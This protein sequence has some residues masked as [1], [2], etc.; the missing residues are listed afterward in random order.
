M[1]QPN[2]TDK[3]D[4]VLLYIKIWLYM[5][6]TKDNII[7]FLQSRL[8]NGV[9]VSRLITN[10]WSYYIK[11]SELTDDDFKSLLSF[12]TTNAV[13]VKKRNGEY[14]TVIEPESTTKY[15]IDIQAGDGGT[16]S[17]NGFTEVPEGGDLIIVFIPNEGYKAD[18]IVIDGSKYQVSGDNYTMKNI[19]SNHDVEVD[20]RRIT[21]YII[22]SS[23][24]G[25][26]LSPNGTVEVPYGDSRNFI[27]HPNTGFTISDVLVD[28]TSVGTV[29][30][31]NF[32]NVTSDHTIE[33][34]FDK[35]PTYNIFA[36]A[37]IYGSISP[38]GNVTVYEGG[39]Q[40][41][42]ITPNTARQIDSVLVDGQ[43][44]G[45][46]S[47]YTF[48]NVR[49]DHTISASF[50]IA[51]YPI[52]T[53]VE[54]SGGTIS[55][56]GTQY[57]EYAGSKTFEIIPN[58]G[59]QI[60]Q[61]IINKYDHVY[62]QDVTQQV[63]NNNNTYTFTNVTRPQSITAS[64]RTETYTI[65]PTCDGYSTINPDYMMTV[66]HGGSC[67]FTMGVKNP[68][69]YEIANVLVDGQ[70]VG[71]VSSYTFSNVT[72]NHTIN[73][74]SQRKSGGTYTIQ[75]I[76]E[77]GDTMIFYP[78]SSGTYTVKSG[79]SPDGVEGKLWIGY[80]NQ[81]QPYLIVTDNGNDISTLWSDDG[82]WWG[83]DIASY[84]PFA[85][86]T[87][88][89]TVRV[90]TSATPPTPPVTAGTVTQQT[91]PIKNG[92]VEPSGKIVTLDPNGK[93]YFTF[94]PNANYK[95]KSIDIDKVD[96]T[97]TVVANGGIYKFNDPTK[98][99]LMSVEFRKGGSTYQI[100]VT[101]G[102]FGTVS[103]STSNVPKH[104]NCA[105]VITPDE[106]YTI[107]EV[108]DNN[109]DVTANVDSDGVYLITDVTDN[110]NVGVSFD[111]IPAGGT[112]T[113]KTYPI[114]NGAVDPDGETVTLDLKG[115]NYFTFAPN[116]GYAISSVVIDNV[117]VTNTVDVN[118][119]IYKFNDPTR[120]YLMDVGFATTGKKTYAVSAVTKD[121]TGKVSP[122]STNIKEGDNCAIVITP[123]RGYRIKQV[124]DNSVDVT[125]NV[126]GDGVY[127]I[128]NV[129]EAHNVLVGFEEGAPLGIV[130]VDNKINNGSIVP[131]GNVILNPDTTNVFS[132][133]PDYKYELGYAEY[134]KVDITSD[135]IAA[136][137]I[138]EITNTSG[139]DHQLT[140][141][142]NSTATS[143][144]TLT[145][146]NK[147]NCTTV[148][149]GT[150]EV[151]K[152]SNVSIVI[153]PDEGYYIS[154]I[155]VNG[156]S[157]MKNV[158]VRSDGVGIYTINSI[159]SDTTIL[160]SCD[161]IK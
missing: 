72:A 84:Q 73:V 153:R 15:I 70:N 113:Q 32:A 74:T 107:N 65:T 78:E 21:C 132:F 49:E 100:S 35:L 9:Y 156:H 93:N 28:G 109:V 110:H 69:E 64:F 150:V 117:D 19:M 3:P 54:G 37:D 50:K 133:I 11:K 95:I 161:Q 1:R 104:L 108:I 134:D 58:T 151:V 142:F 145:V 112:V 106:G 126:D 56:G 6:L 38:Q 97:S 147:G 148:P 2:L 5:K 139:T 16:T 81:S 92:T 146:N 41:F 124:D 115:K 52:G 14:E 82:G 87:E 27:I 121:S 40:K 46:V 36:S 88:N 13:V 123:N 48:S 29:S 53:S 59:Y 63:I 91:Y 131:N 114:K 18:T 44:V 67:T 144:W 101:S 20:F 120:N 116:E 79:Q 90:S 57:V 155:T 135:V 12:I 122:S 26:S 128:T 111:L 55:P 8:N 159:A 45:A 66:N 152:S 83:M 102:K 4:W 80:T 71:A 23:T 89:H 141:T 154:D 24:T 94:A 47:S 51:T 85:S 125:A 62:E 127:L 25:G 98:N 42:T 118:G 77:S 43:N 22:A 137:G 105:I 96:V 76:N 138:F 75:F 143:G 86:V 61:V 130:E 157:D 10:N 103:P 7:E 160:V 68:S 158:D 17:P 129:N 99:Y 60:N 149:S 39:S 31:Y 30:S 33:V 140:A 136:G 34:S 119:N